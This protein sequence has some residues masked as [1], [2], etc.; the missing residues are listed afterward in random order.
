[1]NKIKLF[2]SLLI[3]S[4]FVGAVYLS[5]GVRL[6]QNQ[7]C[8]KEACFKIELAITS[9]GRAQGL[10]YRNFLAVDAGMLFV[11]E[12]EGNYP[13]WMKNTKIPL[14]IIWI[15]K[16]RRVVFVAKNVPPCDVDLCLD[17]IPDGN[18]MYVLEINAGF[19]DKIG[20]KQGDRFD[21]KI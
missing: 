4:G 5:L 9:E 6:P 13:F 19:A 8:I 10:M 3:L 18:A 21:F 16:N 17:I 12:Q 1:M 7:V 11:F 2:I 15:D 20:I 14:D